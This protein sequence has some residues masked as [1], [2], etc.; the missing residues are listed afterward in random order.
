MRGE[1]P[2]AL[3]GAAVRASLRTPRTSAEVATRLSPAS[4]GTFLETYHSFLLE[5]W[6]VW[7]IS[8]VLLVSP[9]RREVALE[10]PVRPQALLVLSWSHPCRRRQARRARAICDTSTRSR[11]CTSYCNWARDIPTRQGQAAATRE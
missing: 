4:L 2:A 11:V 3:L 5:I 10:T 7:E 1:S 9:V 8:L 6:W